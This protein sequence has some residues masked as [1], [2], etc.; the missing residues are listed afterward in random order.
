MAH[1]KR[2]TVGRTERATSTNTSLPDGASRGKVGSAERGGDS[3]GARKV[4][5]QGALK[6]KPGGVRKTAKKGR[7]GGV[8]SR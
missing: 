2:S 5:K 4:T 7:K 8:T 1:V 6:S 3:R